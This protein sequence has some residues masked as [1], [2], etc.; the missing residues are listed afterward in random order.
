MKT[1]SA[2]VDQQKNFKSSNLKKRPEKEE[3]RENI[4]S[5]KN[6]NLAIEVL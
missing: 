3:R 1:N 5:K 4:R 2:Q 6:P